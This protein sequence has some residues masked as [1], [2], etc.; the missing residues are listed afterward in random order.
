MCDMWQ[1]R[2]R[3]RE[4]AIAFMGIMLFSVIMLLMGGLA[5]DLARL[6]E[7]KKEM[8]RVADSAALQGV[9][10]VVKDPTL[11][12]LDR[13][14]ALQ[15]AQTRC[16]DHAETIPLRE[17]VL[18]QI[19]CDVQMI[20]GDRILWVKL[21]ANAHNLPFLTAGRVGDTWPVAVQSSASLCLVGT[22]GHATCANPSQV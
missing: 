21:T 7:V 14:K 10:E 13:A 8:T 17:F 12:K 18:S 4:A 11:F 20:D 1:D 3:S 15:E 5:I 6:R 19:T 16:V 9:A 22:T 2:W